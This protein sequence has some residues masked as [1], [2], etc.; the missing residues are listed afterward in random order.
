M[1]KALVTLVCLVALGSLGANAYLFQKYSTRRPVLA[2]KEG[3]G[4]SVKEFRDELE[5]RHGRQVLRKLTLAK[6]VRE[7]AKRAGIAPTESDI[8]ARIAELERSSPETLQ[9]AKA[10]PGGTEDVRRDLAVELALEN[11]GIAKIEVS[12]TEV[13]EFYRKHPELFR[14]PRQSRVAFIVADTV[15]DAGTAARMLAHRET[16]E[17]TLAMETGMHVVG[18][19]GFQPNLNALP[20]EMRTRLRRTAL[21]LKPGAVAQLE[22]GDMHV[23]LRG[24]GQQAAGVIPFDTARNRA[25]RLLRLTKARPRD[26]T[27]AGLFEKANVT[28]EMDYR[29]WFRDITDRPTQQTQTAQ[30][31]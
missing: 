14:L 29:D 4:V 30:A 15:V 8:D 25:S 5:Y 10:T 7:A 18:L 19:N 24:E 28:F 23:V 17:A 22:L 2:F 1:K 6:I 20:E 21:D 13:R 27:L 12:D 11:I 16:T 31:Q 9:T 26:E 3:G